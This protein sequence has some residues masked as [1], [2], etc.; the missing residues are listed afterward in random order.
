MRGVKKED[1][2]EKICPVCLR[3]FTWRKKW[4]K[5]WS[6]VIYCSKG[7]SARKKL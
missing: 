6:A 5:N 1:L 7:C 2:P 3:P 4:E